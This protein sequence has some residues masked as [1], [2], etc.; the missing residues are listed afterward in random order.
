MCGLS[1]SRRGEKMMMCLG[2]MKSPAY[3]C[4]DKSVLLA[5]RWPPRLGAGLVTHDQPFHFG[6]PF[7]VVVVGKKKVLVA[8]FPHDD[9]VVSSE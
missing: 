6:T 5:K 1:L 4:V 3:L 9:L 2:K 8:D 7:V